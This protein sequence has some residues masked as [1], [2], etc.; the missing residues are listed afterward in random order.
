MQRRG[1]TIILP[2]IGR[3]TAGFDNPAGANPHTAHTVA[4]GNAHCSDFRTASQS[5]VPGCADGKVISVVAPRR[6][7]GYADASECRSGD[8]CLP[9]LGRV[10]D[11]G[12]W[13]PVVVVDRH[14]ADTMNR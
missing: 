14:S 10:D 9:V 3:M 2:P 1:Y 8:A 11:G 12:R 5:W 4:A 13:T 6:V 7:A